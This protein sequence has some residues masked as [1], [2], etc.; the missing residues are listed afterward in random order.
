MIGQLFKKYDDNVVDL[1]KLMH[2]TILIFKI[3]S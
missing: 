1:F 2:T 3:L